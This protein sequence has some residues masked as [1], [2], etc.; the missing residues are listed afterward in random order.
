MFVD[1]IETGG[2][3][4]YYYTSDP[5]EA[6]V[7]LIEYGNALYFK[8]GVKVVLSEDKLTRLLWEEY[9]LGKELG[10]RSAIQYE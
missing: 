4:P 10:I 3:R 8:V 7:K 1:D 2:K 6:L 9:Y 5:R